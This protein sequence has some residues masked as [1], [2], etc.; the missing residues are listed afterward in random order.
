VYYKEN[1]LGI[2]QWKTKTYRNIF[3]ICGMK[4]K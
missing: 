3:F 1:Y 4:N 2:V